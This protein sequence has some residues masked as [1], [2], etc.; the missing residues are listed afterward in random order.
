MQLSL[1][2]K[3]IKKYKYNIPRYAES[4]DS[5]NAS[6]LIF[7]GGVMG[8]IRVEQAAEYTALSKSRL[9]KLR[10][11]DEGPAF[12]KIGRTVLYSTDDLAAWLTGRRR[13]STWAANDNKPAKAA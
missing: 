11:G 13:S 10:M 3:S 4:H 5:Q 6:R 7:K 8:N 1:E 9:D 12:F 2:S